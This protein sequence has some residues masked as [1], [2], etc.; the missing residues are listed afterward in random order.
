MPSHPVPGHREDPRVSG[1]VELCFPSHLGLALSTFSEP[2]LPY[3]Q[4]GHHS[5]PD[6]AVWRST[7]NNTGKWPGR[8]PTDGC[9]PL[10]TW[11]CPGLFLSQTPLLCPANFLPFLLLVSEWWLRGTKG[12]RVQPLCACLQALRKWECSALP[13][14]TLPF[15]KSLTSALS[16]HLQNPDFYPC[17]SVYAS[18]SL[19]CK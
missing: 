14:P 4:D 11:G 3:L 15:P 16:A 19:L 6:R 9:H 17:F 12:T 18:L 5:S 1:Q 2:W 7:W 10:S 8:E 13:Y